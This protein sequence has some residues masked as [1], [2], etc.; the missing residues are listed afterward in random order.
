MS[1][2]LIVEVDVHDPD[3]YDGYKR[4][5][6]PSL[7]PYGGKFVVRGGEVQPLE[8]GWDPKRLV[9]IEFPSMERARAWYDSKEYA[10][11]KALR[12]STSRARIVVVTGV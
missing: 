10:E 5:V 3:R 4:L 9:V 8:G 12:H 7:E 1:A 6:P 2:Y 11:A